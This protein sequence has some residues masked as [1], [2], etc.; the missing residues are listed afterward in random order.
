MGALFRLLA[1]IALLLEKPQGVTH[2]TIPTIFAN[3]SG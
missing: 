2:Q 1:A 3:P